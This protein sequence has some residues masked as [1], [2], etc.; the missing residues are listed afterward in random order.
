LVFPIVILDLRLR[1]RWVRPDDRTA[2][3]LHARARQDA[4]RGR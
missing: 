2:V 4:N 1:T 3:A